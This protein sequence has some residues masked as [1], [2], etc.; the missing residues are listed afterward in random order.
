MDW[1]KTKTIFIVTFLILNLFLTWQLVETNS[2]NQISV[3]TEATIQERLNQMNV[4]IEAELPEEE[5]LG[6]HV[7]SKKVPLTE[8]AAAGL[9]EQQSL[10]LT[11]GG[12]IISE[13]LE[14]YPTTSEQFWTELQT[15][16][17]TYV[18][19]GDEYRYGHFDPETGQMK[20][21]QTFKDKTAYTFDEDPLVLW[22]DESQQIIGYEQSYYEFEELDG[23]EREMLSSLKALEVLLNDQLIRANQT[24]SSIEFGYYSFFSPQGGVQVFAPMWRVMVEDETYLV[25][26][27]EGSVQQIT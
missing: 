11:E 3:I 10:R 26:A 20:L 24:I 27:I 6:R 4:T 23:R 7:I 15:F 12:E 19:Q 22:F 25:N 14:P 1:S 16:L 17:T 5:L 13:L 21:Y 18:Y 9:A 2:A 8:E